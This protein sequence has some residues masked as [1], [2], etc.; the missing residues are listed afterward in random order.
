M[1]S[2][3]DYFSLASETA[4]ESQENEALYPSLAWLVRFLCNILS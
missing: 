2:Y 1:L 4:F 3:Q